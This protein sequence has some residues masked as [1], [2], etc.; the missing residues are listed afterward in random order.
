MKRNLLK[1][2]DKN[3]NGDAGKSISDMNED[4]LNGA[5]EFKYDSP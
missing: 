3:G 2:S 4:L 1:N 5:G